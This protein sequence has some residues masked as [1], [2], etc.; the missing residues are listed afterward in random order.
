MSSAIMYKTAE[1]CQKTL[2]ASSALCIYS[3]VVLHGKYNSSTI[4]MLPCITYLKPYIQGT[5]V[6][7][8]AFPDACAY[9]WPVEFSSLKRQKSTRTI[10]TG[11]RFKNFSIQY[12]QIGEGPHCL[13]DFII[14]GLWHAYFVHQ[15]VLVL[16]KSRPPAAI[17]LALPCRRRSHPSKPLTPQRAR[18]TTRLLPL[19]VQISALLSYRHPLGQ[20][21]V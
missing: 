5:N 18:Y 20:R 4:V 10:R 19:L 12:L 21:R 6:V 7:A 8:P 15:A 13:I 14:L 1:D 9:S 3:T 17:S 2:V 11:N 16:A